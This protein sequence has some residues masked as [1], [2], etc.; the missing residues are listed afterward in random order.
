M[1]EAADIL[2]DADARGLRRALIVTALPLER[3]AVRAHLTEIG[4]CVGDDDELYECFEYRCGGKADDATAQGWLVVVAECGAGTHVAQ[5][6]VIYANQLFKP[7]ELMMFIG[8]A[9]SRKKDILIG[10][11]VAAERIYYPHVGKYEGGKFHN[12]GRQHEVGQPLK[13]ITTQVI[14]E[15]GWRSRILPLMG[16]ERPPEEKYPKPFPPTAKY[17]PIVSV[18]AVSADLESELEKNIDDHYQDAH[19]LEMEGYGAAM[20]AEKARI[21]IMVIRGISDMR[22]DKN[23]EDDAIFQPVAAMHAAAFGMRLLDLWSEAQQRIELA[24]VT[25]RP[26]EQPVAVPISAAPAERTV[27]NLTGSAEDYTP[28]EIERIMQTLREKT[29]NPNLKVVGLEPG[30]IRLIVEGAD[31]LAALDQSVLRT[32]LATEHDVALVGTVSESEYRAIQALE[33]RLPSA[34]QDL[35]TWPRTLPDGVYIHRPEADMLL[36]DIAQRKSSS[37]VL[38]GDPGSGKSAFLADIGTRLAEQGWPVLAIKADLLPTTVRRDID[39]GRELGLDDGAAETVLRIA[40]LRPVVVL[41]DQLDALAS[42]IDLDTG[43]LNVLL[44]LVRRL[45]RQNNVHLILSARTF[46]FEHDVRLRAIQADKLELQL[47]PW[48]E[49]LAILAQNGVVADGWPVDAQRE[50]RRPQALA[51]YLKL[52]PS[53]GAE[54]FT[55]YQAMLD[56]LWRTQILAHPRGKD[57]DALISD[58]AQL[59]ADQETLWVGEVRFDDRAEDV[60]ALK[61][62]GV[63]VS[64]SV[65]SIGFSH[66]TLFEHALARSFARGDGALSRYV[67]AREASLFLRPKLW[68]ALNYLRAIEAP[69]YRKEI[70]TIWNQPTLRVHLRQLLIEFVGQQTQPLDHEE[71]IM[72]QALASNRDRPIALRAIVGSAGWFDR[73]GKRFIEPAMIEPTEVG[74]ASAILMRAWAFAPDNV[75]AMIRAKWAET[76]NFDHDVIRVLNECPSWTQ[77]VANLAVSIINR[78]T[79]APFQLDQI[80]ATIGVNHPAFAMQLVM[81]KLNCEL[82]IAITESE[83][84]LALPKPSKDKLEEAI[85]WRFAN[86]PTDPLTRIVDDTRDWDSLEALADRAPIV[87]LMTLWP[88]FTRLLAALRRANPER[89]WVPGFAIPYGLDPRF[90]GERSF[91]LQETTLLGALRTALERVAADDRVNFLRWL[92][93]QKNE[94]A[95][96]AQRFFAHALASQPER[97]ASESLAF[98]IDNPN[99]LF[100][101]NSEDHSSTSKRLIKLVSPF[102]SDEEFARFEA[103]L[104]GYVHP[105]DPDN[106]PPPESRRAIRKLVRRTRLGLLRALAP[107]RLSA[108]ASKVVTEEGRALTVDRVGVTYSGVQMIGSPISEQSLAL[109][110]DD[111]IIKAFKSIPDATGWN[112]PTRWMSG[113]NVQLSREF[114]TFAEANPDRAFRLLKRFAPVFGTRAAGYALDAMAK[115]ADPEQMVAAI[116]DLASRGFDGEEYRGSVTRAI[117][118]LHRRDAVIGDK[119]IELLKHWLAVPAPQD[120]DEDAGSD[121]GDGDD[122]GGAVAAE[123]SEENLPEAAADDQAADGRSILWDHFGMTLVPHGSFPVLESLMNIL[124]KRQDSDGMLAILNAQVEAGDTLE[125]WKA[126][127]YRFVYLQPTSDEAFAAFLRCVFERYPELRGTREAAY[128]LGH[129]QWRLPEFVRDVLVASRG[130]TDRMEQQFYGELIALIAIV[131]PE[132]EWA[133]ASLNA[134]FHASTPAPTILGALHSAAH[135]WSDE[136]VRERAN[137]VLLAGMPLADAAGWAAILDIF[138]SADELVADPVTITMLEG[139]AS[140]LPR[141]MHSDPT[142]VVPALSSLLPHHASMIARIAQRLVDAQGA[143]LA[144]MRTGYSAA[145]PELIDLAITLHRSGEATRDAGTALFEALMLLDTYQARQTLDEI[146]NRFK[147][148]R[149]FQRPRLPRRSARRAQRAQPVALPRPAAQG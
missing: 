61:A 101:G 62:M 73:L 82:D 124:L 142:F 7:F 13:R 111:D 91:G 16:A 143:L 85:A 35:L 105:I 94:N 4:H 19:A 120:L 112:H 28:Y 58:L 8:I 59:M 10:S 106:M 44:N 69:S 65:G 108:A 135:L 63:L 23:P 22:K 49:V 84:R 107:E 3:D 92:D 110:R 57:L 109:S 145:V 141:D 56:M 147:E 98:L 43:R 34:S 129:I 42:Y 76:A 122:D 67:L 95:N 39:L 97:Y 30:S 32:A 89:D 80:V 47:P 118:A 146:D 90:E 119:V 99:R 64:H 54:P 134:I 26:T 86:S 48:E 88:W 78:T 131:Q 140:Y 93:G 40:S 104:L 100:L 79:I 2:V 74:I 24:P 139:L 71:L 51:T 33:K 17:A 31:D 12:R 127:T 121:D 77:D 75:L 46:E 5:S 50:M 6:A 55:T 132:L 114:A 83:R 60:N 136:K 18:E 15:G 123:G 137:G 102:W 52:L 37:T 144:D 125:V 128:L 9:A 87:V 70:E 41:I 138:R 14:R 126:L 1:S 81:A 11:V 45:G 53:K 68:A 21:P 72:A 27:F 25:A 20:A 103:M 96:P 130:A 133:T 116:L 38:L 66:Q 29:G 113:G 115:E 148:S 36:A 149:S 117:D